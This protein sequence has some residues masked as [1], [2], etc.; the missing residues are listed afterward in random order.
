MIR[1]HIFMSAAAATVM[2]S[3]CSGND[4]KTSPTPTPTAT[5]TPTPTASPTY[6]ALP[7]S[8]A[9]EFMTINATTNFT[10]DIGA[11]AVTLGA[12]ATEQRT[13][14]VRLATSNVVSTGTFVFREASE[15]TRFA[16]A[17]PTTPSAAANTEFVFRSDDTTTAGKFSQIE[18]LNNVIPTTVTSEPL[19]ASLTQLSYGNWY[20]GDSTAG[21]KRLTYTVF[22]YPTVLTDMPTSGTQAYTARV[23]GRIVNNAGATTVV[24]RIGGTVTLSVNFSTGVVNLTLDLT[25]TATGGATTPYAT[26]TASGA[27]PAGQNQFTGSIT[28]GPLTG[29]IAGGF[30]GSQG[31]QIGLTF[32]GSGTNIRLVGDVVGKKS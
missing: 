11:G 22:G 9:A 29:T 5:P 24:N 31:S 3:S 19:F 25:Q 10:G 12:A 4:T 26:L 32:A 28:G 20:R 16:S 27:I 18:F 14:R 17:T 8:G 23:V 30:F 13:D 21:Q 2:L 15:E 7:L 6:A 1:R